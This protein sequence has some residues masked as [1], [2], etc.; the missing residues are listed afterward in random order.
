ML[1]GGPGQEVVEGRLSVDELT[2]DVSETGTGVRMCGQVYDE[3][4]I[5]HI[6]RQV[7]ATLPDQLD[8][9]LRRLP[10]HCE[11]TFTW[12]E[13]PEHLLD[14]DGILHCNCTAQHNVA[15][16]V[17]QVIVGPAIQD[18]SDEGVQLGRVHRKTELG[19]VGECC[20]SD[21]P[22]PPHRQSDVGPQLFDGRILVVYPLTRI[23]VHASEVDNRF[24][25]TYRVPCNQ[26]A[27]R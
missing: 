9:G 3:L 23:G 10:E 22:G 4:V 21:R 1:R 18:G 24:R 7:Q 15:I 14:Q 11:E 2:D 13:H 19:A 6:A 12:I 27:D 25:Q 17:S 8:D 20:S 26:E 5:G 16:A